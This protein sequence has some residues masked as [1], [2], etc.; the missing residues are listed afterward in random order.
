MVVPD[1]L[2]LAARLIVAGGWNPA[3]LA[4][5]VSVT[6]GALWTIARTGADVVVA[7]LLSV[8]WATKVYV[9]AGTEYQ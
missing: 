1:S 4:G 6:V 5:A 2:A 7:P 9:P 8:P 3:P